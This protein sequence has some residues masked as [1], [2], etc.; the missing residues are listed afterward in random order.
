[1]NI[2]IERERDHTVVPPLILI[3]CIH[4]VCTKN[5]HIP[6]LRKIMENDSI[7]NT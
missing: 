5:C 6:L 3:L 4:L 7:T 2:I 1:M